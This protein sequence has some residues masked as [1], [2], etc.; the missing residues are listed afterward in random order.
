[1]T[2]VSTGNIDTHPESE[3]TKLI[4]EKKKGQSICESVCQP[5]YSQLP[6]A[7]FLSTSRN[8]QMKNFVD[9]RTSFLQK[10]TEK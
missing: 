10:C 5:K 6:Y 1:M 8:I 3:K 7:K 9:S 4:K 2:N